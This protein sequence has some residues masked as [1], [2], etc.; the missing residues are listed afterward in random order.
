[1]SVLRV[2]Q[3]TNKD[4]DGAVEFSEGLTFASNTSISGAGGI[5]LT[6]IV[7]ATSFVGNG[8]NLTRTDSVSHSKMVAL[9]YIT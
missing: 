6:G 8:L 5:N 1:M 3:I 7:T 9:T 2:N 4:D